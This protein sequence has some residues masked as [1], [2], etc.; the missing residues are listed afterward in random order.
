M[1]LTVNYIIPIFV[2]AFFCAGT[3]QCVY[4]DCTNITQ[5]CTQYAS[6]IIA[7]GIHCVCLSFWGGGGVTEYYNA[8]MFQYAHDFM[9]LHH[10]QQLYNLIAK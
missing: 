9:V 7:V 3:V 6:V 10:A 5:F 2:F 8:F 1:K 4:K